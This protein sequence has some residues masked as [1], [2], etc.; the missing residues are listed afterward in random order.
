VIDPKGRITDQLAMGM[1][2]HLDARLPTAQ[3]ATPYYK[4]GDWP[5]AIVL[6]LGLGSLLIIRRRN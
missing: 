5:L 2:G 4:T 1:A 6:L 3:S